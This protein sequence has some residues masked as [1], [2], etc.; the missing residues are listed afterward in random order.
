MLVCA[1]IGDVNLYHLVKIMSARFQLWGDN[2]RFCT[3]VQ[4]TVHRVKKSWTQ[5][6]Q[7]QHSLNTSSLSGIRCSRLILY[8]LCPNPGINLFPR[9]LV[10]WFFL[11]ENAIQ[12][13]RSVTDTR[14]YFLCKQLSVYLP[15]K[16]TYIHIDIHT[17]Y[18]HL[19]LFENQ[20]IS[21]ISNYNSTPQG[22]CNSLP[23]SI[24]V[25][26]FSINKGLNSHYPKTF[27]HLFKLHRN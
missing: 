7:Q 13:S 25:T 6:K 8:C 18:L 20:G 10:L 27:I 17:P 12:K 4:A 21:D 11:I 16:H 3:G 26:P 19:F 22:F 1:S 15:R 14:I 2:L 9:V 5:L 23:L 24:F